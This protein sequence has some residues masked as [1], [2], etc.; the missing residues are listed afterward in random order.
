MTATCLVAGLLMVAA[1]AELT[2]QEAHISARPLTHQDIHDYG[3]PALTQPSGGL[4]TVGL[5]QP[6]Y[7]E[8][9]VP[10]ADTNVLGVNWAI[11]A[12]PG[13][14]ALDPSPLGMTVPIYEPKAREEYQ[15]ASRRMLR[16]T[17]LGQ[18]TVAATIQTNG[19]SFVLSTTITAGKYMGLNTC[20]LCHSGGIGGAPNK[21]TPW[22]NTGHATFFTEAIDGIKSSHYNSGCIQCHVVGFD[23]DPLAVNGGFDDVAAQV[24]WT[25]PS[26]LT[27]GN[28]A[29]MPSALKN[30][31]NIQCENCHGPG[32]QHAP[33][34]A[35]DAEASKKLIHVNY[36]SGDC[37]QCHSEEPYHVYPLQWENSKHAVAVEETST[38][39]VGCHQG[40]G[41][42]D[43]T[44]G[45]PQN[46]RRRDYAAINC[47]ACHEPH[48][49]T[50]PHQ[51]RTL[52]DVPLM[53]NKT[54]VTEGG[55]G[56]LCMQCHISRR[57]AT[58]YVEVTTGSNRYGPHHGPQT[59][60]FV[61][62]NAMNYEKEIPSSAHRDV[63][64]DSCV[65]CHMQETARTS[66]EHLF[67]GGH[68][69]NMAWDSGSNRVELV[70]ACIQCHGEIEGF[71]FKRQDYDGN[72]V[73]DGIQTEVRGLLSQLAIMLPPVGV[74]KPNHSPE[75]LAIN[76]S[77]TRPQLRAAYNYLFVVEDGSYG[78]HNLSYAVGLLKASIAD[79]SGDANQDGIADWWQKQYFGDNWASDPNAARNASP[80]GDGVP[81][82]L[83]YTLG[84]DPHVAGVVVPDGVVWANGKAIGGGANTIHIY[85][86]AEVVFDTEVGKQYQI[87][88]ASEASGGWQNMGSPIAGTGAAVSYVTPTRENAQQFYRV[89]S[90]P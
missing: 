34:A 69:W 16:P 71:D 21:V 40:I 11:T 31:S 60:M 3:L 13:T 66:P 36:S 62:A 30:V 12:Q 56:K 27:N 26:V 45:V 63:V 67:A 54:I 77:W 49:A 90:T 25:F 86:A 57:N 41:F 76:S 75:N 89:V 4:L 33:V 39:C 6:A 68:T 61:G 72:G 50:N 7:L 52:A 84:L 59:D 9:L 70:E 88:A 29:A 5:G 18:Y 55:M 83:K 38:S 22:L 15:V 82:W 58:N 44:R 37:A 85:T 19:G 24:G 53:D 64:G 20:A 51:I 47:A 81:N 10:I 32:S 17:V 65:T 74:P 35:I 42:I 1:T 28:W 46:S 73:I 48:D 14:D 23:T 87:Q 43:R 78:V 79:L 8:V 2:A 80:A